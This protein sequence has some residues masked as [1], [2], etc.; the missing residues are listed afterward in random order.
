MQVHTNLSCA[1]LPPV[2]WQVFANRAKDGKSGIHAA[3][4]CT[5]GLANLQD[6][7]C[8]NFLQMPKKHFL[9]PMGILKI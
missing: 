4:C 3:V 6:G 1:L 7:A 8:P 5:A 2:R 9:V